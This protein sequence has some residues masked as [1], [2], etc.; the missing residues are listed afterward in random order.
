[1]LT[2]NGLTMSMSEWARELNINYSTLR[3]R[4]QRGWGDKKAIEYEQSIDN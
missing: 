1:M 2:Y 4:L 3:A